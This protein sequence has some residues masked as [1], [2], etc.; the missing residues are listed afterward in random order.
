MAS[1][2]LDTLDALAHMQIKWIDD[3]DR[4][5]GP[6]YIPRDT[7]LSAHAPMSTGLGLGIVRVPDFGSTVT[8]IINMAT[9]EAIG[10]RTTYNP[11]FG[12][13]NNVVG[14][15]PYHM[16]RLPDG[17]ELSLDLLPAGM[18]SPRFETSQNIMNPRTRGAAQF[19]WVLSPESQLGQADACSERLV[20]WFLW[21]CYWRPPHEELLSLFTRQVQATA[22]RSLE[23]YNRRDL[24]KTASRQPPTWTKTAAFTPA[25]RALMLHSSLFSWHSARLA[26]SLCDLDKYAARVQGATECGLSMEDALRSALVP[27]TDLRL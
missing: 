10:M 1:I 26:A 23:G 13:L 12:P 11:A 17:W 25:F 4:G 18:R 27:R 5:S 6:R 22:D 15:N 24:A 14:V 8:L 9:S 20:A 16:L 3:G 7:K 21:A 19:T 2:E